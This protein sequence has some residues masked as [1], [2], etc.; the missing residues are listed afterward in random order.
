VVA[1]SVELQN[2]LWQQAVIVTTAVPQSLPPY[3]FVASLNEMNNIHEDK[4]IF[5][6]TSG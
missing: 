4:R 1:R 3:R 5:S 6:V 2:Q